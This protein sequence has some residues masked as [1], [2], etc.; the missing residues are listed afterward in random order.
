VLLWGIEQGLS[1]G[2]VVALASRYGFAQQR[3]SIK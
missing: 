2:I 3:S 1:L